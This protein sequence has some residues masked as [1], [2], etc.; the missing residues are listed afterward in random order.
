MRL[1]VPSVFFIRQILEKEP[2]KD[3]PFLAGEFR[4]GLPVPAF[5]YSVYG[6]SR[7]SD[8]G[9]RT[10]SRC[11]LYF[12]SGITI[13]VTPLSFLQ[14]REAMINLGPDGE[15]SSQLIEM[16][17][18]FPNTAFLAGRL[19]EAGW[20]SDYGHCLLTEFKGDLIQECGDELSEVL[21]YFRLVSFESS[22][23]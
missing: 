21:E 15:Q 17:K 22:S 18:K 10:G 5:I 19:K 4:Q 8:Y 16:I 23:R 3:Q 2:A 7:F 13:R 11:F 12:F 1:I 6:D 14:A 9:V 20:E